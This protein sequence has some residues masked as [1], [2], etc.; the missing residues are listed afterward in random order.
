MASSSTSESP[1]PGDGCGEGAGTFTEFLAERRQGGSDQRWIP[2]VL[3]APALCGHCHKIEDLRRGQN[4]DSISDGDGSDHRMTVPDLDRSLAAQM[5][6]EGN[7]CFTCVKLVFEATK[8]IGDCDTPLHYAARSGN[9]RMLF[10]LLCLLGDFY[11]HEGVELL[12][13]NLNGNGETALHEAIKL[14]SRCMARMLIWVDPHLAQ[15]P[16]AG[17]SPLYLAVSLGYM[18]IVQML[19]STSGGNLSYSGPHGQNALHAAKDLNGSTP[20]HSAVSVPWSGDSLIGRAYIRSRCY[21][22]LCHLVSP[23]KIRFPLEKHAARR[24]LDD[25]PSAAYQ[26]DNNGLFPVHIAALMD[27]E[28]AFQIII[29]R[30]PGCIECRDMQ[31]KSFLHIA[32]QNNAQRI[33]KYACEE[34]IFA[35]MLN[36][37]DNDGNTALH[38]A[39][40][41]EN[42]L[43]SCFLLR[44]AKVLLNL[45][46]NKDQT[47]LDV[48]WSKT[49]T[50]FSYGTNRK[51]LIYGLL[52]DAG[53][54]LGSL[55]RD[56]V[57]Q[58]CIEN[59]LSK[60]KH[61]ENQSE[62][63][64]EEANIKN[65]DTN[66][67]KELVRLLKKK[68]DKKIKKANR[69]KKEAKLEKEEAKK[70]RDSD[71]MN[72]MT[73]TLGVLS[74]LIT[75]MT[76]AAAFAVP[77]AVKAGGNG[78][79]RLF[80]TWDFNAFVMA[81]ALAFVC[82]LVGTLCLMFSGMSMVQLQ[83]RRDYFFVSL[84]FT[85]SSVTCLTVAFA[86]GVRMVL[87]PVG[88]TVSMAIFGISPL[89]LIYQNGYLLREMIL[90]CKILSVR[91]GRTFLWQFV[92]CRIFW[93]VLF[94]FWPFIVIFT[95]ASSREPVP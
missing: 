16:R 31:G 91:R 71:Q 78:T 46:N 45:R 51:Y 14:G 81:N 60:Q 74:G 62:E 21:I 32:V 76:F 54:R 57:Q 58:L 44:N 18:H 80:C 72:D 42:L 40:E 28:V 93:G 73:R 55:W 48:A 63:L 41:V 35:P 82:S 83:I 88:H 59:Q 23:N 7:S 9:L 29:K 10:H 6:L 95:W 87:S 2:S 11:G 24:I 36:A 89:L 25:N 92:T 4:S 67:I 90:T 33:V 64:P 27:R 61:E 70:K 13:R 50:I 39:V 22:L 94:Q 15:H 84:S 17:T 56:R 79:P 34:A 8:W 75:T 12:L 1:S 26:R 69:E 77:S 20:L 65:E 30:W 38:I 5:A 52:S 37:R 85:Y 53:A 47:P 43:L 66:P 86:L 3:L 68:E 49:G 19:L